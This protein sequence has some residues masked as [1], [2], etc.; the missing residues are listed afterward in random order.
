MLERD[1]VQQFQTGVKPEYVIDFKE[2]KEY[3]KK[4]PRLDAQYYLGKGLVLAR[5]WYFKEAITAFSQGLSLEPFN[6]LLYRHRGH[7]YISIRHFEEAVADFELSVRLDPKNWDSWYH[8]GLAHYLT[9]DFERANMAYQ[10][11]LAMTTSD[12]KLV[13]I[14]DWAWMTLKKLGRHKEAAEI[15]TRINENMEVGENIHY[16]RRL[17]MYKGLINPAEVLNLTTEYDP[18]ITL[19]TVGYG[20]GNYYL[21]QG[22]KEEAINVYKKVLES[23]QWPAFGYIAAEVDIASL[24][25]NE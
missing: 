10:R 3:E 20:L 9:N 5:K 2:L 14:A 23:P 11:C 16:H 25:Y 8:L 13:A 6:A 19:A 12:A 1:Q 18:E 4:E 15:L 24:N 22:Q 17:L 21:L 7:R